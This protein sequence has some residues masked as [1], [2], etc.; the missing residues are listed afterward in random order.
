MNRRTTLYLIAL[1]AATA[2]IRLIGVG[3]PLLGNFATKNVVYAMIARNWVN[4][5]AAAWQPTLKYQPQGLPPE[6]NRF[7]PLEAT[8]DYRNPSGMYKGG[9]TY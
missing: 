5:R 6:P 9:R 1:L 8:L 2:G 4:G 7:R 3:R